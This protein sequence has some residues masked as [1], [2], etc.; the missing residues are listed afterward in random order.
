MIV[1][2]RESVGQAAAARI[3]RVIRGDP[4]ASLGLAT[5]SSPLT[6]YAALASLVETGD[7]DLTEAT[8]FALD[9]YVGLL[10]HSEHSYAATLL[11]EVIRP[12][13]MDPERIHVPDGS[14]TDLQAACA[15][16]EE[17]IRR[18]GGIDL[19]ILGIGANGHIGF[20]EPTSSLS[21]RT[22]IKTLAPRTRADNARFF[23][24]DLGRVPT[25]CLTQGLGTIREATEIVLVAHGAEKAA[26]VAAA[27][28]G[29][30]TAMVPASALQLHAQTTVI[31]DRAAASRL[32]LVEYYD[33]TLA[34]LPDWQRV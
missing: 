4:A 33:H 31:L 2:D 11:R 27:V 17:A 14:A 32:S 22:R 34:N 20:N 25:H 8:A 3:R 18:A 5:G 16:F 24:G 30:L 21:S 1:P 28:E 13:R 23:D 26:A 10:P 12:L 15:R 9:E 19:Q 6:A 29:P 7:L